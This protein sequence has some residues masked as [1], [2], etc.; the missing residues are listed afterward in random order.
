[1]IYVLHGDDITASRK[2]LGQICEEKHVISLDGKSLLK[3]ELEEKLLSTGLFEDEKVVVIENITKNAKKKELLALLDSSIT[4]NTIIIWEDKKALK[5]V[6]SVLKNAKNEEFTLPTY[7]FKFLDNISPQ[8]KKES[9]VF[10]H[11]LLETYA[12]EQLLFSLIKRSRQL[13]IVSTGER[14]DEIMKMSSW[15][16]SNLQKQV[17]LW[18]KENL[19]SFYEAL[20]QTEIKLKT[21]GLPVSLS[22]HLDII[23][24]SKL[25]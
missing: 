9:F 10:Y 7:Y 19:K 16:L 21:G 4:S 18:K 6:F 17:R 1:M 15:Q 23:L 3:S 20:K 8:Y 22:K 11:K 14:T 12:P 5:T 2:R 25:T 24:L 13:V